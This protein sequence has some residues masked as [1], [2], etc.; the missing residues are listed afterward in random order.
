MNTEKIARKLIAAAR[1]D[2][3]SDRVPYAFEQRIMAR[4]RELPAA[5][6]WAYWSRMLWRA[7]AP[8]LAVSLAMA[9]WT[10]YRTDTQAQPV[11]SLEDAVF[12]HVDYWTA[13]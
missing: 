1:T 2:T 6:A 8:C 13:E 3:P 10:V 9:A 7:A 4:L 12:A 5:D 11:P